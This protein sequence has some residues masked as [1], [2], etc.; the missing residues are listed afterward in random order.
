MSEQAI[1][2][3]AVQQGDVDEDTPTGRWALSQKDISRIKRIGSWHG[4]AALAGLAIWGAAD[5]WATS[6]GLV[7]AHIVAIGN[8]IVVATALSGMIHEWGHFTGAKLMGSIAPVSK[9][10]TRFYFMF[11]FDMERNSVNQFIGLS[12]GGIIANWLLVVAIIAL[13]P[14]HSLAAAALLAV[15]VAKAVN[16]SFFEVPVVLRVR[17]SEDPSKELK[18]QLEAYGLRQ[19]PGLIAGAFAFLAFT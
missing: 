14:I 8:A 2:P 9:M 4:A 3:D 12:L 13:I 18:H 1:N 10:P 16:V 19:T 11:N 7:L 17:E 6:S 15:A 5:A